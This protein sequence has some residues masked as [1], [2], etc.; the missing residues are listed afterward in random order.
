[1]SDFDETVMPETPASEPEEPVA[2]AEEQEPEP[3]PEPLWKRQGFDTEEAFEKKVSG[4]SAW[5]KELNRKASIL[6]AQEKSAPAPV[7]ETD[8]DLWADLDPA[9]AKKLKAAIASEARAIVESTVGPKADVAEEL[10]N[11]NA[12]DLF[13]SFSEKQGIDADEL[14]GF[15]GD[16]GL[17][18]QRASLA[19][20]KQQL[21]LAADAYKGRNVESIVD[22]RVAEELAKLKKDGAEVTA[23]SPAAKKQPEDKEDDFDKLSFTEKLKAAATGKF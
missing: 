20:L 9:T 14:Y 19:L 22:K 4:L 21:A 2:P 18:P 10:F 17:F 1:V 23:V 8:D 3:E 5:E 16:H 13:K 6:G 12:A 15:M 11:E 7:E